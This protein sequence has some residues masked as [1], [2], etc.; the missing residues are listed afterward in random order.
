MGIYITKVLDNIMGRRNNLRILMVGLDGAGKT[1][2]LYKLKLGAAVTTIPTIG[3]NVELVEYKNIRF[4]V[5]DMGGQ[6]RMRNLWFH[7]YPGT[8]A[9]IFIVDSTDIQRLSEAHEEL[10]HMMSHKDLRDCCLL[11]YANK[12]D[13][14]NALSVVE[15]TERLGLKSLKQPWKIHGLSATQGNGLYEGL[16]YLREMLLYQNKTINY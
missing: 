8:A 1:T 12:Q 11:V 16:E 14:P 4:T 15:L 13:L 9:V 3:F 10:M 6:H 2:V 5:W 7:Y